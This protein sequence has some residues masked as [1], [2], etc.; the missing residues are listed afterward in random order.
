MPPDAQ[1]QT[2][3]TDACVQDNTLRL[4]C[5]EL[6]LTPPTAATIESGQKRKY[7]R[8][9]KPRK[10]R[11]HRTR[12]DPFEN[13]AAELFNYFSSD[14]E[15]TAKMLLGDLQE[16]HPGDYPDHLL[17]TLQRRIQGWRGSAVVGFELSSIEASISGSQ[18]HH[19]ALRAT[20]TNTSG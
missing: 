8:S 12:T 20:Q 17:R 4:A 11:T 14:P 6:T 19:P 13:V 1:A 7:R 2:F 15:K 16:R 5:A 18:P 10:P 3:A 9:G